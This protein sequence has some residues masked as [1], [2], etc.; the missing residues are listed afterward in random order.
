[1]STVLEQLQ[2]TGFKVVVRDTQTGK[3]R[4]LRLVGQ[5]P[6]DLDAD[7]AIDIDG[8]AG[9]RPQ[10]TVAPPPDSA[11]TLR[12]ACTREDTSVRIGASGSGAKAWT[13][14]QRTLLGAPWQLD[15]QGAPFTLLTKTP[16]LLDDLRAAHP[17]VTIDTA[18]CQDT[19]MFFSG[20]TAADTAARRSAGRAGRRGE[21]PAPRLRPP[22]RRRR[23]RRR[24]QRSRR[25]HP[26]P[27]RSASVASAR[28]PPPA[29][30]S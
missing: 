25:P 2:T 21:K 26:H 1:M 30:A 13:A 24:L 6:W 19:D 28:R 4:T 23:P 12:I 22:P 17:D 15:A 5:G 20:R 29:P 9:P 14:H 7:T 3:T 16:T 18:D 8:E 27:P 10:V 11:I